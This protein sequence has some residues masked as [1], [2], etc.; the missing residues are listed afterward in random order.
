MTANG[1]RH[2]ALLDSGAKALLGKEDQQM[3]GTGS[4]TEGA[5]PDWYARNPARMRDIVA[6]NGQHLS[7]RN[8][9]QLVQ[10]MAAFA[11]PGAAASSVETAQAQA[12]QPV[13]AANWR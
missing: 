12:L 6:G 3:F 8:V 11:P 4:Y 13:L 1:G 7:D 9:E 5:V 2:L 10:A